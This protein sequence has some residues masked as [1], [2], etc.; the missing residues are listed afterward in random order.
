MSIPDF[1]TLMLPSIEFA[2]D[3]KEHPLS[4]AIENL[5]LRFKLT[6]A[7]RQELLPSGKQARFNNRVGWAV[8]YLKKAG[9]LTSSSRGKFQITQRGL[10]LLK[11][12]PPRIDIT[13]LNR[14]PEFGTFRSTN[15]TAP[16][17][18]NYPPNSPNLPLQGIAR[19]PD[20][21]IMLRTKN[22]VLTSRGSY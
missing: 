7:E 11:T 3:G 13:L 10:D 9:L 16:E 22:S 2:S 17:P 14:F 5:A 20:E 6:D 1:Q 18:D 4:E 12:K 19:T 21:V 8:T 15:T